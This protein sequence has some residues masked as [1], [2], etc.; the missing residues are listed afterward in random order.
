MYLLHWDRLILGFLF[1]NQPFRL[2]CS[3]A[4][5]P[6]RGNSLSISFV[7]DVTSGK[8][9]FDRGLGCS[10]HR[11]YVAIGIKIKLR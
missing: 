1:A 3:H 6:C 5:G 11:P 4:S 10:R 2:E 9:A 7:L 8:D